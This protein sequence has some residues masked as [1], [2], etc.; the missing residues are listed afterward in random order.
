MY[1]KPTTVREALVQMVVTAPPYLSRSKKFEHA[2][3]VA[4]H[5]LAATMEEK[6]D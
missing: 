5:V 4:K 2:W 6:N 1:V 3:L